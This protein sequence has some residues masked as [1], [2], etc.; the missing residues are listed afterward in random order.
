MAGTNDMVSNY[1]ASAI[2]VYSSVKVLPPAHLLLRSFMPMV[3]PALVVRIS[4]AGRI[5]SHSDNT[6]HNVRRAMRSSL[7]QET[8]RFGVGAI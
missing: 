1:T 7:W 8:V 2:L 3:L 6:I 4:D 5:P